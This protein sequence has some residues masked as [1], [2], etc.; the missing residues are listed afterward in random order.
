LLGQRYYGCDE[1]DPELCMYGP[2]NSIGRDI[3]VEYARIPQVAKT[4]VVTV[5]KRRFGQRYVLD[6]SAT[7][8][9]YRGLGANYI[10]Q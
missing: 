2:V 4:A 10:V 1:D 8:N 5:F 9:A 6:E 7:E 3:S